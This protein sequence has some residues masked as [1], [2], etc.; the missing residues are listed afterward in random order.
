MK[1]STG[2]F[3]D[4]LPC[5]WN[6]VNFPQGKHG[7]SLSAQLPHTVSN[8]PREDLCDPR[9]HLGQ[10][11]SEKMTGKLT[12]HYQPNHGIAVRSEFSSFPSKKR[13]IFTVGHLLEVARHF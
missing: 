3:G 9:A 8:S 13:L 4:L 11:G 10:L 7:V 5:A 1:L 2:L 6:Q 12:E